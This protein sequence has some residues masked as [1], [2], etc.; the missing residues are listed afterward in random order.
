MKIFSVAIIHQKNFPRRH[1]SSITYHSSCFVF[2]FVSW[3]WE[4]LHRWWHQ[5][6]SIVVWWYC[7]ASS[8]RNHHYC[9]LVFLPLLSSARLLVHISTILNGTQ[10]TFDTNFIK[11]SWIRYDI[12][13]VSEY[14]SH[15]FVFFTFSKYRY[16][17]AHLFVGCTSPHNFSWWLGP[18]TEHSSA[19]IHCSKFDH[20]YHI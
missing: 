12:H 17:V 1:F 15:F 6:T 7:I 4:A 14:S 13:I 18:Y 16:C 2:R 8:C 11:T 9:N 3:C 20:P 5:H 19:H 10:I